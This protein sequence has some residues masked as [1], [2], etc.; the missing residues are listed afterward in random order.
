MGKLKHIIV[1]CMLRLPVFLIAYTLIYIAS[2]DGS[3]SAF[4]P[5]FAVFALICALDTQISR[6]GIF[7][8]VCAAI[9][10]VLIILRLPGY[11]II[12]VS[13]A[14]YRPAFYVNS[15]NIM[16]IACLFILSLIAEYI[17]PALSYICIRNVLAAAVVSVLSRQIHVLDLFLNSHYCRQTSRKTAS[18][19]LKR[20]YRFSITCLACITIFG[21]LLS[22]SANSNIAETISGVI[23]SNQPVTPE[24]DENQPEVG[25]VMPVAPGEITPPQEEAVD[26]EAL[27]SI[28]RNIA[29]IIMYILIAILVFVLIALALYM[30]HKRSTLQFSDFDEITEQD[31]A[32][33]PA[34]ERKQRN[35]IS[36]GINQTV[37]R[38]FRSKVRE[39]MNS[40]GLT[41]QKSDTPETLAG[42][43]AVWED[44]DALTH[45]YHEARYSGRSVKRSELNAYYAQRVIKKIENEKS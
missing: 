16:W 28:M 35:R 23:S 20:N 18:L 41:P 37:R 21:I 36:F 39:H 2:R 3:F 14:I 38:L 11:A 10:L 22:L 32:L 7:V 26:F 25:G 40:S 4:L 42:R 6:K 30:L 34:R 24:P 5:M 15:T 1:T 12:A 29:F 19:I 9:S 43:I 27:M 33:L 13:S 45:L 8:L 31:P 17:D 44:I